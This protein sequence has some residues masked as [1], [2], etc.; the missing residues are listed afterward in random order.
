MCVEDVIEL[1]LKGSSTGGFEI[2]VLGV[3]RYGK[4]EVE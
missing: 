3:D 4:Q 1:P 2:L